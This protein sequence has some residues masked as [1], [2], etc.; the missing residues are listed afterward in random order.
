MVLSKLFSVQPT[1]L[2]DAVLGWE[3]LGGQE[4]RIIM[5]SS[6]QVLI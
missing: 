5:E 1:Q 6:D 4:Q 2:Y 3:G